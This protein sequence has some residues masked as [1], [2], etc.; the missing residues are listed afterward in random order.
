MTAALGDVMAKILQI[1]ARILP[2]PIFRPIAG[3]RIEYGNA[4]VH[5]VASWHVRGKAK[6]GGKNKKKK[7]KK[8]NKK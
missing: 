3:Y 1:A 6:R 5:T 2:F 8:K 7:M 4:M